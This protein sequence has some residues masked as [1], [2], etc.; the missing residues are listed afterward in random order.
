LFAAALGLA[1]GHIFYI[2][3]VNDEVSQWKRPENATDEQVFTYKY[4]WAFYAAGSAFIFLMVTDLEATSALLG[5]KLSLPQLV[6][7][8]FAFPVASIHISAV[9]SFRPV[10][11]KVVSFVKGVDQNFSIFH[12]AIYTFNQTFFLFFTPPYV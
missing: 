5:F 2:S 6:V 8:V 1:L 3:A 4:G 12:W 11:T 7:C 10:K 9:R